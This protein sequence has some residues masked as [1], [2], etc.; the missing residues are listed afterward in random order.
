MNTL[1]AIQNALQA[2]QTAREGGDMEMAL[3]KAHIAIEAAEAY[4]LQL[5][6]EF[7]ASRKGV[8]ATELSPL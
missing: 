5:S 3:I 2:A 4:A 8:G 1:D 6:F 7:I